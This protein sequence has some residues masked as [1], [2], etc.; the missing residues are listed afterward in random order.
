MAE[1]T[2]EQ[3]FRL[4]AQHCDQAISNRDR[5]TQGWNFSKEGLFAFVQAVRELTATDAE[6]ERERW[7]AHIRMER[8]FHRDGAETGNGSITIIGRT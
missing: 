1:P 7:N 6:A 3:I 2:R 4:A 8:Y 5:S